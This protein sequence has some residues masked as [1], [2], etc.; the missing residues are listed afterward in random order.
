MKEVRIKLIEDNY[1]DAYREIARCWG[2]SSIEEAIAEE[3]KS[4]VRTTLEANWDSLSE[5]VKDSER[6][7]EQIRRKYNIAV[8]DER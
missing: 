8:A 3:I 4:I 5:D 2:Y 1:L 7:A 6:I